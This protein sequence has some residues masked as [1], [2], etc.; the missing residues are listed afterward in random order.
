MQYSIPRG[1]YD[2]LPEDSPKWHRVIAEFRKL[3]EA[4]GYAEIVTPIFEQAALFERSS[5]ESSDV[6]K[7]EMYRFTDRKGREFALRP[8]GTAPVARSYIENRMDIGS[9]YTKLYYLGPMFRY[10][11]P[12]AGRYRQFYQYGVEFIGSNNPYYDAEII[13]ILWNYLTGL[14]LKKLHLELNSVGCSVCAKE[15]DKALRDYFQ[16]Y[17]NQ[18]CP[19]CQERFERKPRRILDCKVK[20]CGD[21]A[22]KAP[23][24]LDYLDEPCREHFSE[25]QHYLDLMK[26]PFIINPRIVRG[27]DYYTNTA[28]EVIYEGIGAQNALAGGGR[29]NGLL[30]QIGGKNIPAVGFAGGFERLFLSLNEEKITLPGPPFPEV[31]IITIG[32]EAQE[33]IIPYLNIIRVKGIYAEYEP[34]RASLKAQLKAANNSKAYYALLIGEEEIKQKSALLKNL[35]SGEQKLYSL[36]PIS[37]LIKTIQNKEL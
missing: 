13:A 18:L 28:F 34:D 2:I 8:E 31:F 6:V 19:D 12:Q 37:D 5:G 29:Y 27:L 16:P 14:G 7:K 30:N 9:S 15:Y 25:V 21:I 11:R 35:E 17:L 10:D 23:I 32:R 26:I 1:T 33:L 3:V 20:E 22:K 36:E 24:Q 4:Y